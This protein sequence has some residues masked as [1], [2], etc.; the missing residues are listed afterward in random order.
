VGK[1]QAPPSAGPPKFKAKK[2][3]FPDIFRTRCIV[4]MHK[5]YK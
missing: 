2:V 3:T 5:I 4:G 1:V